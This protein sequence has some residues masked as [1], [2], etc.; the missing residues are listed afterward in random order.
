MEALAVLLRLCHRP[1][2]SFGQHDCRALCETSVNQYCGRKLLS[3]VGRWFIVVYFNFL[4]DWMWSGWK[5][6]FQRFQDE[7]GAS[8]PSV[9]DAFPGTV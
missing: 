6:F 5:G 8:N 9:L 1:R 4:M 2:V 7:L 3:K